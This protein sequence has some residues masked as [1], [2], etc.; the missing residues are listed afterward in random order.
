MKFIN[1]IVRYKK[2][3]ILG[4]LLIVIVGSIID[5]M[6]SY[7]SSRYAVSYSYDQANKIITFCLDEKYTCI[8]CELSDDPALTPIAGSDYSFQVTGRGTTFVT[9]DY[10]DQDGL[11][12]RCTFDIVATIPW[13]LYITRQDSVGNH[14]GSESLGY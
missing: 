6:I 2:Y 12:D 7:S 14:L 11:K 13:D 1:H 8:S 5:I 4:V 3:Y 9:F 10:L